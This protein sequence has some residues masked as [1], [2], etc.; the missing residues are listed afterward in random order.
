MTQIKVYDFDSDT[1]LLGT[2]KVEER[3]R[4]ERL[5]VPIIKR[6]AASFIEPCYDCEIAPSHV[7]GAVDFVVKKRSVERRVSGGW[8]SEITQRET[9]V[10]LETVAPLRELVQLRGFTIDGMAEILG[11]NRYR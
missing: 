2:L 9:W 1:R 8:H 6:T 7:A 10:V 5:R 4:G 11:A 3:I